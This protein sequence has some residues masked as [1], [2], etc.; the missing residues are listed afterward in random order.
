M[1]VNLFPK[2][3]ASPLLIFL[4]TLLVS[5]AGA[6]QV[7]A[8][9]A[10]DSVR[11]LLEKM[12]QAYKQAAY[13]SFNVKYLYANQGHPD[14]PN[15]SLLGMFQI[16]RDR[17]RFIIDGTETLVTSRHTIRVMPGERLMYLSGA[18]H[19][20]LIDPVSLMD[21][22]FRNL[23]GGYLLVQHE[24]KAD[25][26]SIAFP[27]GQMYTRIEI[28]IDRRTGYMD[29]IVYS[30]HTEEL[31]G[32]SLVRSPGHDGPYEPEGQ[33]QVHFSNY[34]QK[35]FGDAVF[36]EDNFITQVGGKYQPA[37]QYKEYQLFLASPNL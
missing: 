12:Q 9:A 8:Q 35:A 27:A 6:G 15:D 30:L 4:L 36:N 17:C 2:K 16:D 25:V 5:G 21:S 34:R 22:A 10:E 32:K 37:G 23:K 31:V 28:A 18:T 1:T 33:V 26:V 24:E 19:Q 11:P 3:Y 7:Q 20:G 13:L 29:R 14:R